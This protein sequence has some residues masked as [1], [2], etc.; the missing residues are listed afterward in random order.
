MKIPITSRMTI[1]DLQHAFNDCFPHLSLSFFSKPHET[2]QASPAKYVI[3]ENYQPIDQV[4]G[5]PQNGTVDIQPEMRVC[6]L[7]QQFEEKFG[8]HV[9][10]LR[11]NDHSWTQTTVS[12]TLTLREQETLAANEKDPVF[13][14]FQFSDFYNTRTEWF[15]G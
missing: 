1:A 15:L 13:K 12:D 7:E 11:Q 2:F 5:H 9:Q 10:V 4:S 8:L 14:N 3:T 6:E